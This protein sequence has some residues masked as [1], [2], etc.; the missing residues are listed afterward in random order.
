M[1]ANSNLPETSSPCLVC[2]L[3]SKV[4]PFLARTTACDGVKCQ[5]SF[6]RCFGSE[7]PSYCEDCDITPLRSRARRIP[8]LTRNSRGNGFSFTAKRNPSSSTL[9]HLRTHHQRRPQLPPAS[10]L[11]GNFSVSPSRDCEITKQP[12]LRFP[13]EPKRPQLSTVGLVGGNPDPTPAVRDGTCDTSSTTSP[14]V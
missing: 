8:S 5:L 9:K 11:R 1:L 2:P 10:P 7:F 14:K 13:S 6:L 3:S 4:A 12:A